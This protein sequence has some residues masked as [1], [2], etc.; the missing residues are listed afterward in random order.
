MRLL[1]Y[2]DL[3]QHPRRAL[4]TALSAWRMRRC[5]RQEYVTAIEASAI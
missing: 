1:L 5:H 3:L 4:A 2:A